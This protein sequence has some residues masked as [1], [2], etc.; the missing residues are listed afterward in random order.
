MHLD[1]KPSKI[2]SERELA[3]VLD[4]SIA[5]PP[6]PEGYGHARIHGPE[7]ARGGYLNAA[8]D[9]WGI[10]A[11]L[12]EATTGEPPFDAYDEEDRYEQLER[13][14]EPVRLYSRVPAAFNDLV[15]SCLEHDEPLRRPAVGELTAGLNQMIRDPGARTAPKLGSA[16]DHNE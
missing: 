16:R 9:V 12:F 10:G 13:R 8:T 7:Q 6:G 4:L 5:R 15:G 14:A 11:V 1:L 2:I 3:K